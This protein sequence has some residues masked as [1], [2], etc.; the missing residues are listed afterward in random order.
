MAVAKKCD[1]CGEYYDYFTNPDI[2]N[3]VDFQ[4]I[5]EDGDVTRDNIKGYDICGKCVTAI[6]N[7]IKSRGK[8]GT[9]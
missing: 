3:H 1:V 8:G 7:L 6:Y 5:D 4:H 2:V 9:T